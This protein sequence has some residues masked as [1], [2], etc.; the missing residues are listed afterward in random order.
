[1]C[2]KLIGVATKLLPNFFILINFVKL[3]HKRILYQGGEVAHRKK[4]SVLPGVVSCHV[5]HRLVPTMAIGAEPEFP[6][7]LLRFFTAPNVAPPS[8]LHR[9]K[10]SGLPGVRSRHVTHTMVPSMSICGPS[11]LPP[12]LLRFFFTPNVA[13][14]SALH[15]NKT[16]AL[17]GV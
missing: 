17:P 8:A 10:T 3:D 4:I 5:T 9:T 14:P 2:S 7:L 16:S 13:P 15:R 12:L 1:M 11:E 6:A